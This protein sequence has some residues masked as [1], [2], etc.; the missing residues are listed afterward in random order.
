MI[1]VMFLMHRVAFVRG[2]AL[3]LAAGHS[4]VVFVVVNGGVIVRARSGTVVSHARIRV[5]VHAAIHPRAVP[6]D[7]VHKHF[8][9]TPA[10][11]RV[12]P[13]PRTEKSADADAETKSNRTA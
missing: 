12:A 2:L 8:V 3:G 4:F 13:A 9:R 7:V 5:H 1:V 10:E 6:R 11:P